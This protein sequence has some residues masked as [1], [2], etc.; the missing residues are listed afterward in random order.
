MTKP[1]LMEQATFTL[2]LLLR[3]PVN[4]SMIIC[5]RG[6]VPDTGAVAA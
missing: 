2:R 5:E 6:I 3:M 1:M 4:G